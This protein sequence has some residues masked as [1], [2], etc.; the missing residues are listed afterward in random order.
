VAIANYLGDPFTGINIPLINCM[1]GGEGCI[2][3]TNAGGGSN[4]SP[5][6][7]QFF[8]SEFGPGSVLRSHYT[9]YGCFPANNLVS[10]GGNCCL[11]NPS[12]SPNPIYQLGGGYDFIPSAADLCNG[13]VNL[14][15][16][17]YPV[18]FQPPTYPGYVW[19]NGVTGPVIS[20]STP[21][22]YSFFVGDYCHSGPGQWLADTIVVSACCA[23]VASVNGP[24]SV[25]AG[26]P[27]VFSSTVAGGSGN[28]SYQW[29]NGSVNDSL[30]LSNPV[31]GTYFLVVTDNV[32]SCNDTV[33][34]SLTVNPNPQAII[35]GQTALCAGNQAS[36]QLNNASPSA[37]DLFI[38]STG[39][40]GNTLNIANPVSGNYFGV[41]VN[42][43]T[44]C[45]D[46][47]F[48]SLSVSPAPVISYSGNTTLC[49]GQPLVLNA[50]STT[51]GINYSW[52]NGF[53]G[54]VLNIP[55]P[56]TGL[57]ILTGTDPLSNCS[58]QL[59]INVQVVA[60]P[61][62]VF[63]NPQ[64]QICSGS[65]QLYV[66]QVNGGSGSFSYQWST[67]QVGNP[68]TISNF[69]G[70][71]LQCTVTD[72]NTGCT[73]LTTVNLTSTP[74]PQVFFLQQPAG[75][76]PGV[77]AV[78]EA[79]VAGGSGT[80]DYQWS[81]GDTTALITWANPVSGQIQCVITDQVS[82][83]SSLLTTTLTLFPEP[84][85][86]F[87]QT[88]AQVCEGDPAFFSVSTNGGS[89]NYTYSWS[90]GQSGA[91]I[92][93]NP[94]QSDTIQVVVTDQSTGCRD[95]VVTTISVL[96]V[97]EALF[98]A[99]TPLCEGF[100]LS[101]QNNSSNATNYLWSFGNGA[102]DTDANPV[103]TYP[104]PGNYQVTL[105]ASNGACADTLSLPVEVGA[106][107]DVELG[108]PIVEDWDAYVP[109]SVSNRGFTTVDWGDGTIE[110]DPTGGRLSHGY[111]ATGTYTIVVTSF[112]P[113]G[114]VDSDTVVVE[115][116]EPLR[117]F[118]PSSFTPNGDELNDRFV[119]V[120]NFKS[121]D[122]YQLRIFNRWG[123]QFFFT[124]DPQESW[125]GTLKGAESPQGVYL[126]ELTYRSERARK[127]GTQIVNGQIHL[128]R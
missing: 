124:G 90:T 115:I 98:S 32:A 29:S 125:D 82:G 111:T 28:Y 79:G 106:F 92:T 76:C 50:S 1:V 69:P 17:S 65:S 39:T 108:N 121:E 112:Q 6:I 30:F 35:S 84:V 13:N 107:P 95:T 127:K 15:V 122:F 105:V 11:Q 114:C 62:P 83:C 102:S 64:L 5:Q 81:T 49:S 96:P 36:I 57:I 97:P 10:A 77:P 25:C 101:V 38:W 8:L 23:L 103:Y 7:V 93:L 120:N 123:Q 75:G 27:A 100:P 41:V 61:Q 119:V 126:F 43:Q 118:I 99:V 9:D 37:S 80:Y 54:A 2:A 71:T 21:G 46:T 18:L 66:V 51:A 104:G 4:S 86:S 12:S 19:S 78:F 14:D 31:S 116:V 70:G 45:R 63:V 85:L 20:I 42:N 16:S 91:F 58:A 26:E 68:V 22:T 34:F 128:Y 55:N 89:G 56:A 72:I 87:D 74:S 48:F 88:T 110:Q 33:F 59:N 67:G 73:G 113:P 117:L 60:A 3:N 52:S 109:F 40:I 94:T 24:T 53:S 44:G 47:A